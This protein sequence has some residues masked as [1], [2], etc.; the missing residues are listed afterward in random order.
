MMSIAEVTNAVDRQHERQ[1]ELS[2]AFR[3]LGF[4]PDG[5]GTEDCKL[6]KA[7]KKAS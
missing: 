3:A 7:K 4:D 1:Q 6:P 2:D 5:L